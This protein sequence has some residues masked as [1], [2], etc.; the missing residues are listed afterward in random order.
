MQMQILPFLYH[1]TCV[2]QDQ[3][4]KSNAYPIA[5]HHPDAETLN[6]FAMFMTLLLS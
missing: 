3:R 5:L 2:M 1:L 6:S 4:V